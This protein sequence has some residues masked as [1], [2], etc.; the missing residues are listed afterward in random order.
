MSKE[1]FEQAFVV[2]DYNSENKKSAA[3]YTEKVAKSVE[4]YGLSICIQRPTLRSSTSTLY[5]LF[6][7]F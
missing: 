4:S 2:L 1:E 6:T 3:D 7:L 5:R